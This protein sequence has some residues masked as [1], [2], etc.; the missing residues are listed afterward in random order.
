MEKYINKWIIIIV[1]IIVSSCTKQEEFLT[2]KPLDKYS[3]EDV[4]KSP[5]LMELYVNGMYRGANGVPFSWVGM[6]A[7]TD[8]ASSAND[9]GHVLLFNQS[10]ITPD[11]LQGWDAEGWFFHT[12]HYRW[13]DL[14]SEVRKTN[15]FLSKVRNSTYAST[16]TAQV[17]NLKGQVYFLRANLYHFLIALYGGVPIITQPSGL[18]EDYSVARNSYAD[19]ITFITHQLDS[20]TMF[21]PLTNSSS[22]Q[23]RVTKG[24][25]MA[26]K[27]RVLLY[28][29]SPLHS[30][31]S[32]YAPG[33]SKPE[34]LGYVDGG[35][36]ARWQ[37]AKDAAKAVINLGI[38][39]L[40][41]GEPSPGDSIAKNI[42]EYFYTPFTPEDIFV[43]YS[44]VKTNEDWGY[45]LG[46]FNGP[47]GYH[48]WGNQGPLGE[49]VDDYEMKDGSAFN[50][51]N[52][53]HKAA[54]Y[55]NRDARFYATIFYEGSS[56]R[57]RPAD[58]VDIDPFNKIQ[59]GNV[60]DPAG[61][62]LVVGVDTRQSII[63]P[64]NGSFT[65][66]FLRKYMDPTVDPLY[67]QQITTFRHIRYAEVLLNYAEA[68]VELGQ[69][70]EA[71]TYL[72]MIRKRAGQPDIP[73]SVTGDALRQKCHHERKIELAFEDQRFFDVK[74]WLIGAEAY[75][76]T[77]GASIKYV[78]ETTT[79]INDYTRFYNGTG[80]RNDKYR[81]ADGTTWGTPSYSSEVTTGDPR[82]WIDKAY[83]FPIMRDETN[84]N[85]KL[86]QNP[87]YN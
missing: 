63:E 50:W 64:W 80:S 45:N 56:W 84:K 79:D 14:Y 75:K 2:L 73:V 19:C 33:Y 68:C 61:N 31:Q 49:F 1:M 47:N 32:E 48:C 9:A 70:A 76:P 52:P 29:A 41:K 40:Y 51:N 30:K 65:N 18:N 39:S 38:Y 66:Y 35:N 8:E 46:Q 16:D 67:Y 17:N 54:P 53:V 74:R 87:G 11:N 42:A 72:N 26:L 21:L 3:D 60:V 24:A 22:N 78:V 58:V 77:L 59:T 71:R 55:S 10:L 57:Q 25:A 34:L 83:F 27:A 5:S 23:G 82:A 15:V 7:Y 4:W 36:A 62:V 20:A 6:S 43:Q 13:N 28:A 69:D 12:Q 37:A 86:I 85:T 44:T 81:K